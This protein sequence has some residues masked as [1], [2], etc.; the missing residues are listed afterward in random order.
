MRRVPVRAAERAS[1]LWLRGCLRLR[2][3][4]LSRPVERPETHAEAVPRLRPLPHLRPPPSVGG[5][6][7]RLA[8]DVTI[9]PARLDE[10]ERLREIAIAAK[11]HWGYELARVR[12]WAAQS[13]F[14]PARLTTKTFVVAE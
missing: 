8:V 6:P 2:R 5:V 9:R 12:D 3:R 13:D 11:S 10:G 14:S 7:D 4:R 1:L